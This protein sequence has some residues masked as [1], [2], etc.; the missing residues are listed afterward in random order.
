MTAT[1]AS[2]AGTAPTAAPH[3]PLLVQIRALLPS[4]PPSEQRVGMAATADPSGVAA[5]TIGEL[6]AVCETSETTV[7]RFCRAI[8]LRGYPE[9][10]IGLA[11]AAGTED[12]AALSSVGG[13]IGPR[14]ALGDVVRKLGYADARA[15]E[16]TVSQLDLQVLKRVIDAV[17]AADRV[18]VYGVGASALIALD[19]HQKLHRI[20]RVV[21]AWSDPH[22]AL[23][24]AALLKRGDVAIGISHTG[25][26]P[27]TVSSLKEARHNG[28][29]TVAITEIPAIGRRPSSR[30]RTDDRGAGDHVQVRGHGEPHRRVDRSGL[31]FRRCGP[32]K[33]RLDEEGAGAY[34][35]R[36]PRT[37]ALAPDRT[38]RTAACSR[39]AYGRDCRAYAPLRC[40]QGLAGLLRAA[41]GEQADQRGLEVTAGQGQGV[42]AH[43]LAQAGRLRQN[44]DHPAAQLP[45]G[46]GDVDHEVGV[47]PA[48][49]DHHGRGQA[50]EQELVRGRRLQAGRARDRLGPGGDTQVDIDGVRERSMR[51]RTDQ[52]GESTDGAGGPQC[53][54]HI[55]RTPARGD[56]DDR[57]AGLDL[58][59]VVGAEVH[60]VLAA[61]HWPGHRI[62]AARVMGDDDSGREAERRD[63]LSRVHDGQAPGAR[64]EV[65]Q[66]ASGVQAGGRLVDDPGQLGQHRAHRVGE[67]PVLVVASPGMTKIVAKTSPTPPCRRSG[68]PIIALSDIARL[69]G[70]DLLNG[71]RLGDTPPHIAS[72]MQHIRGD[73]FM[74][75]NDKHRRFLLW[76]AANRSHC[77]GVLP[78]HSIAYATYQKS[79][80]RRKTQ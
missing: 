5:M 50:V 25:D 9:L 18:D 20:G 67:H 46:R 79:S 49:G 33:L 80:R 62:R 8:G 55:G 70:A 17:V 59:G 48:S 1:R 6:A 2:K 69:S 19:L 11:A 32:A 61:L 74:R 58:G 77:T 37:R 47:G 27:E 78:Q 7:M 12:P 35:Q 56:A 53:T 26:T 44:R 15:V 16:D 38:G 76:I 36:R 41:S 65:V 66:T 28:A 4:L 23:T 63:E 31:P 29:T 40:Q 71:A 42:H 24:S 45:V 22:M 10:R 72:H 73:I 34:V 60:A 51:I 39:P 21:N 75:V 64:A 54:L 14:D 68:R 3:Q 52:Y 30:S 13:D 57:I 43:Q